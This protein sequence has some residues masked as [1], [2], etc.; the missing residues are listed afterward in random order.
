DFTE[1]A[2][3]VDGELRR[4]ALEVDV[5]VRDWERHGHGGNREFNEVVL[6]VFTDQPAMNRVFTRTEDHRN[7]PQLLL[8][9]FTGLEGPPDFLPEAFPGRCVAPLSRMTDGEVESL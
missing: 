3:R 7:I 8:P 9:Q 1:V 2:V 4:G 6:H 5:D